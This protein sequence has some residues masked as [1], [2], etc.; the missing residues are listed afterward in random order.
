MVSAKLDYI[1]A[2]LI[3]NIYNMEKVQIVK[4][5]KLLHINYIGDTYQFVAL[6]EI[7]L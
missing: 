2:F 1:E 5:Y 4:L 6:Q 3:D 7:F